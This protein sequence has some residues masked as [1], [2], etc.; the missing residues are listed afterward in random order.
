MGMLNDKLRVYLITAS[1]QEKDE[2]IYK[3]LLSNGNETLQIIEMPNQTSYPIT[4][5]DVFDPKFYK[6]ER[7]DINYITPIL[8]KI[9]KSRSNENGLVFLPTSFFI[10]KAYEALV[11]IH[12]NVFV[13]KLNRDTFNKEYNK[14][15]NDYL[16]F[17]VDKLSK[18]KYKYLIISTNIAE[19]SITF[20]VLNYVVD[21]GLKN[22]FVYDYKTKISKMDI[23]I[24]TKNSQIQRKG[25]VGRRLQGHYIC[26]Y[27][28]SKLDDFYNKLEHE[29]ITDQVID[30]IKSLKDKSTEVFKDVKRIFELKDDVISIYLDDLKAIDFI[31]TK[32]S[33]DTSIQF[34]KVFYDMIEFEKQLN[35]FNLIKSNIYF[36]YYYPTEEACKLVSLNSINALKEVY[37][38]IDI[39]FDFKSDIISALYALKTNKQVVSTYNARMALR[40]MDDILPLLQYTYDNDELK[41]EFVKNRYQFDKAQK[42]YMSANVVRRMNEKSQLLFDKLKEIKSEKHSALVDQAITRAFY[43]NRTTNLDKLSKIKYYEIAYYFESTVKSQFILGHR[44][45]EK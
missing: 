43:F 22:S 23:S 33:I 28:K 6:G 30:I 45:K 3:S 17:F 4:E 29:N 7:L 13:M 40:K 42:K 19:S 38:L 25:R 32:S 21:F 37:K 14:Q 27:D 44:L 39:P 18:G 2:R 31:D 26:A 5:E 11:D 8:Q 9:V 20:P 15:I 1:F 10:D 35:S 41:F 12:E 24:M 16:E 36:L 34:T